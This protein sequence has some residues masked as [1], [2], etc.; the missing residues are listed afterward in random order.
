MAVST[1][2][3]R[4]YRSRLKI[5]SLLIQ[6]V[7]VREGWGRYRGPSCTYSLA[8][9]FSA[10]KL[11]SEQFSDVLQISDSCTQRL[12]EI[13]TNDL[14]FLRICVEGGGCSG[15][16]YKFD[17]DKTINEDD[18]VF[19]KNGAKVVVDETSLEYVKGSTVD[20]H[21][22]LIRSAF[23]IISNPK[24]EHGCSCGSSFSVKID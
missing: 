16:Q 10:A 7:G 20:Y 3:T 22:E 8:R 23:R 17:M 1:L 18:R 2:A 19:E 11:K 13:A 14:P 15:F 9:H 21:E 5:P 4:I 12:K 24:A 6:T